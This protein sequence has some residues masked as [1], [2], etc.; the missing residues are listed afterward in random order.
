M[1]T[2]WASQF[3]R[4]VSLVTFPTSRD[5]ALR[6]VPAL[7]ALQD[8]TL[9]SQNRVAAHYVRAGVSS[10]GM[11]DHPLATYVWQ[12][13]F[14]P[15]MVVWRVENALLQGFDLKKMQQGGAANCVLLVGH[16]YSAAPHSAQS[17]VSVNMAI[18][19]GIVRP[20]PRENILTRSV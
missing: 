14:S 2:H 17:A 5:Q 7:D 16:H 8:R 9:L 15:K 4:T 6:L 12:G 19:L 11:E 1:L 13:C 10:R 3:A 20:A 18:D